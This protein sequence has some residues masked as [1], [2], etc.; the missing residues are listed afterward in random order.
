MPTRKH[1]MLPRKQ[2][3][4]S[5]RQ[6]EKVSKFK[7]AAAVGFDYP[8]IVAGATANVSVNYA[9]SLSAG[10]AALAAKVLAKCE[11]AFQAVVGLFGNVAIPKANLLIAPL[12]GADDGSGGA[13]H[14]G[15]QSPDTYVDDDEQDDGSTTLALFVAELSEVGMATQSA[16]WDCGASAG[17][18]LSRTHAEYL[19]PGVLDG[20]STAAAWLDQNPRPDWITVSE[21]TDQ[22][23]VSTGCGVL[24]LSWLMSQGFSVAQITQAP[25]ATLAGT[26]ANL[27]L[28]PNAFADFN[29]ACQLAWPVGTPCGVTVDNPWGVVPQPPPGPVPPPAPPPV[30]GPVPTGGASFVTLTGLDPAGIYALVPVPAS[31]VAKVQASNFNWAQLWAIIQAILAG[32]G[33]GIPTPPPAA[34]GNRR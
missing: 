5:G 28:G 23:A 27:G 11:P 21:P 22:D 26:Y 9:T 14:Y 6:P 4:S 29:A 12:S 10:G 25:A 7:P 13:Y 16:G 8:M 20:Y 17:E 19:F 31:L 1:V 3:F 18:A 15:C 30:P 2:M 34:K 24:F 33:G 32:W